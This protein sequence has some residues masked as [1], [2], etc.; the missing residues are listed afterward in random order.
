MIKSKLTYLQS[1]NIVDQEVG[2]ILPEIT[3]SL[4]TVHIIEKLRD[5]F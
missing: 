1:G 4:I 3:T 5:F 2:T